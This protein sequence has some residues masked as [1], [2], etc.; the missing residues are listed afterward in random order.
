M[1]NVTA[2][3]SHAGCHAALK[4]PRVRGE[5]VPGE[6]VVNLFQQA[7]CYVKKSMRRRRDF[8]TD[9]DAFKNLLTL[10][11]R[12]LDDTGLIRNEVVWANELRS[13]E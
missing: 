12:N 2:K 10:D 9:R 3:A 13:D 5:P 8:R 4:L 1:N 11:D 6:I 7:V